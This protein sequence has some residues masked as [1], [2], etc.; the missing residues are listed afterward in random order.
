MIDLSFSNLTVFLLI[1]A[2][3]SGMI[4]FNPILSRR[5]LPSAFKA[6]LALAVTFVLAGTMFGTELQIF[7]AV[8]FIY[9]AIKEFAVG[10][11]YGFILQMFLSVVFIAGEVMDMQM[12]VSMSKIYDPSS[13]V[14]MPL[15]GSI[16]NLMF[17]LLFFLTDSH[18]TLIRLTM[19]SFQ[20]IPVGAGTFN[21]AIGSFIAN[22]FSSILS[23]SL[24]LALPVMAIEIITE[25]S[26][27]VLMKAVP[28]INVFVLNIQ[29]KV[30]VG[31]LVLFLLVGPMS[32]FIEMVISN[33]FST[34]QEAVKVLA[35][36]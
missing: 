31:I 19:A 34:M 10:W 28:Q 14:Q 25:A 21:F 2:R 20:V 24:K 35:A 17:F 30:F 4:I 16:L 13:N 8:Q 6:G 9:I 15:S 26:M 33:A 36:P 3:M 7:S 12:G 18:L 11:I 27:G 32:S 29:T 1:L 22:L 23:L 5:N